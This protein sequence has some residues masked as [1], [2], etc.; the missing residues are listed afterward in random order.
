VSS[1]TADA[2]PTLSA[3]RLV[4][5]IPAERDAVHVGLLSMDAMHVIDLA[6][7]GITDALEALDQLPLLRQS[8]GAILHGA[9]R[10][11]FEVRHVHLVAPVPLA[12]SVIALSVGRTEFADPTTLHGP[13]STVGRG[14]A[15]AALGGLAAVV[16]RTL[17]AR[18]T[19]TDAELE[20]ALVGSVLVLGWP[21]VDA[22]D[23]LR[24]MPGAIGPF[25]GVPVREP[26]TITVTRV[27]PPTQVTAPDRKDI[28]PAPVPAE[29]RRLARA[30]LMSHTLRP[31]DL[32]TIFP[33]AP[34]AE[35]TAPMMPG[36]WIR[37]SAPGLGTLSLAV[38]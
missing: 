29:F 28:R 23:Q 16:G 3:L 17:E 15:G 19:P 25:V 36:T 7:L 9:A 26:D 6:P 34:A 11:A 21:Q 1:M 12:R 33:A 14:E 31:G 4:S 20:T 18:T 30:A 10:S 8:A 27:P 13:G 2:A 37:V 5:F 38:R 22:A 32:L 35:P 24:I